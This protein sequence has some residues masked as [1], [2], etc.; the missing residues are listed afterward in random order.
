MS[1]KRADQGN[2]TEPVVAYKTELGTQYQAKIE[3]F[4]ASNASRELKGQV[5][6]I[7]T[8][9]PFPLNRQKRYGN[10]TGDTYR[11]WLT[12]LATQMVELLAP[13]GSI[14]MEIG[15]GWE[16]GEPAMST[17]AMRTLLDFIDEAELKLCQMFVC[18]NPARLPS[19]AEWVTIKRIR[20]KD[21]F[22]HVWWMSR[23][24][25]PKASNRRVPEA[26]SHSMRSLLKRQSYNSGRRSSGFD[27]GETS[28]LTDNGGAIGPNVLTFANTASNDPYR[29]W[30]RGQ[31][32]TAHPA[33][34]PSG[35][36]TFFIRFLTEEG[37][38]VLDPFSGSN[39]TGAAAQAENRNWI[40]IEPEREYIFGSIGRFIPLLAAEGLKKSGADTGDAAATPR[41]SK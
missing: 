7:F 26:Y 14:V 3:D 39:T 11:S 31:D 30:C 23:T 24:S 37:D 36:P 6:L 17:V 25:W 16:Q 9:P 1:K 29:L 4:L 34:M 13:D 21:S 38:L 27:I 15:N 40:S 10:L 18:Y 12:G 33:P 35:L 19:P 32:L 41:P 22:T 5:N 28:F 8:S 20:M 2:P